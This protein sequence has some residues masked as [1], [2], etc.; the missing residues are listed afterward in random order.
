MDQ[1][2]QSPDLNP[3]ERLLQIIEDYWSAKK[4]AKQP[5]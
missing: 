1:L 5:K 4:K 3:N 2:P